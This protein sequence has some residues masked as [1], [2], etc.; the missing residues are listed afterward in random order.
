MFT[1]VSC[2]STTAMPSLA[3][4]C[5]C[6]PLMKPSRSQFALLPYS[7]KSLTDLALLSL[8]RS[9]VVRGQIPHSTLQRTWLLRQENL[10]YGAAEL[11]ALDVR[12]PLPEPASRQLPAHN[13]FGS[14]EDSAQNCTSLVCILS[15]LSLHCN[16]PGA[17]ACGVLLSAGGHVA[18]RMRLKTHMRDVLMC[19]CPGRLKKTSTSS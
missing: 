2:L 18:S 6:S 4:G 15:C 19:R 11:A 12:E 13:G 16:V 14:W 5:R 7:F 8:G 10:G 3:P 9:A 1:G 17:C